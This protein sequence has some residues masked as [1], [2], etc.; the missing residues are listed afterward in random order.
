MFTI[1]DTIENKSGAAV[2]LYPYA[3]VSRHGK[4]KTSGYSVLHEGMVGVV[5]DSG[6]QE[7]TYDSILKETQCDEDACPAPAAGSASPT[8]IG[9]RSSSPTSA[10]N[11]EAAFRA[12]DDNGHK[13]YQADYRADPVTIAPGA[14]TDVTSRVF[15]GAKETRRSTPIRKTSA[16]SASN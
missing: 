9:A 7:P 10:A 15:A 5:G 12:W 13:D 4:P 2:T 1:T 16:S 11:V 8:N 6:V 3:L 14:S